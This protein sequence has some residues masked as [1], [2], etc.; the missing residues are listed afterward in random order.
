MYGYY[1]FTW[2][3]RC[4]YLSQSLLTKGA[5][6]INVYLKKAQFALPRNCNRWKLITGILSV[7]SRAITAFAFTLLFTCLKEITWLWGMNIR[8]RSFTKGFWDA[9]SAW[10]NINIFQQRAITC[11]AVSMSGNPSLHF[12]HIFMVKHHHKCD[13]VIIHTS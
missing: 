7:N 5:I 9:T 11:F 13:I 10:N 4:I 8:N 3:Y 6:A 2:Q 1:H 12:L